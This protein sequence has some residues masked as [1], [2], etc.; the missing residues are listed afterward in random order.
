MIGH[1]LPDGLT[2]DPDS[3]YG[4]ISVKP[5]PE[6]RVEGMGDEPISYFERQPLLPINVAL[7]NSV[8]NTTDGPL[9]AS[10]LLSVIFPAFDATI[11]EEVSAGGGD[12]SAF[13]IEEHVAG[14]FKNMAFLLSENDIPETSDLPVLD[15]A[16]QI[17]T[18]DTK[19]NRLD[20][21]LKYPDTRE[22]TYLHDERHFRP[23]IA[24]LT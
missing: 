21:L 9:T 22:T 13:H 24:T 5:D 2:R 4:T 3:G 15:L 17:L 12:V 18:L 20:T 11:S 19:D 7:C 1:E 16:M 8:I 23:V 6:A 14:R 10:E